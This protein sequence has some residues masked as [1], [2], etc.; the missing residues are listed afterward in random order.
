MQKNEVKV[1]GNED[2]NV[3]VMVNENGD[4]QF[5]AESVAVS[6]GFTTV[7]K[8][9]NVCVRWSRVNEYLQKYLSQDVAKGSYIPEPMVYKLAFKANN[10]VAENFQD[11]LAVE[12]LPA[13]R[14]TGSYEMPKQKSRSS[15]ERL[16]SVNN[17]V[18]I[19]TPLLEKAGCGSKI[20]LLTAKSLYEK[21]EVF[22][23][24]EIE[25]DKQYWDTVHIARQVGIYTKSSGKPSDKAVNEIIRRIG[26]TEDDYTDTW[27]SKGSWQGTVRKYSDSVI[28][29]IKCWIAD[30]DYPEDIEYQQSNGEIK[31]WHVVYQ[32][33]EVA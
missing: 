5:D 19:L 22:L 20:Q 28:E 21:A 3:K 4:Y 23:P 18:K 6:L 9:G 29:R 12:V 1:F 16:A 27:E 17:A 33:R 15:A 13:L 30:N 31:A 2:F 7:A 24:I 8:S 32:S 10:E 11:W 25:S 14:K 26:V